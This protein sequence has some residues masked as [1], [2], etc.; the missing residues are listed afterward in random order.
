MYLLLAIHLISKEY[1]RSV[2]V[3]KVFYKQI[4][5]SSNDFQVK[6]A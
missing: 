4:K 5:L 2:F 1:V 3:V 6:K